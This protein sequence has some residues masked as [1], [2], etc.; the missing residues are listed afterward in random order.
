MW[1]G[2]L[3]DLNPTE[4]L[5]AIIK[6]ELCGHKC[7]TVP[8][9]QVVLEELWTSFAPQHLEVLG[10]SVPRHLEECRKQTQ[11]K[12]ILIKGLVRIIVFILFTL[13]Y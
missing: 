9:L 3:S 4:N 12:K 5:W 13:P 6:W 11:A 2:N 1:P 10:D 7:L 8:R